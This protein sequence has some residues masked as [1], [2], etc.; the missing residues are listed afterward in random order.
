MPDEFQEIFS[1]IIVQD[2]VS[3][4][5]KRIVKAADIIVAYIKALDEIKHKNPEFDHV[6]QRF[7]KRIEVLKQTMPE[8]EY[9]LDTFMN[10]CLATVDKLSRE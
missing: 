1:D 3:A 2:N 9:F 4:E 8:V 6:E 5:Y 10:A 7:A